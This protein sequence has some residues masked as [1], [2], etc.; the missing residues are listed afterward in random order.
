MGAVRGGGVAADTGGICS[1]SCQLWILCNGEDVREAVL[2][3]LDDSNHRS[4]HFRNGVTL[5]IPPVRLHAGLIHRHKLAR[6]NIDAQE[7]EPA[8][9]E[10]RRERSESVHDGEGQ[11]GLEGQTSEHI[12]HPSSGG[13]GGGR[14]L[15]A[16]EVLAEGG[17]NNGKQDVR[18][19]GVDEGARSGR[20]EVVPVQKA[21]GG[22]ER[23]GNDANL[24]EKEERRPWQIELERLLQP[25]E[26]SRQTGRRL[27][28]GLSRC[29]IHAKETAQKFLI[30]AQSMSKQLLASLR[31]S[32]STAPNSLELTLRTALKASMK[33][34]TPFRTT[35]I[36][37]ILADLQ[38][39]THLVGAAPAESKTL[40]RA[41]AARLDA[42]AI[43][44]SASPPR[45]D[46]AAGNEQE[47]EI[48]REFAVPEPAGMPVE[49][50][51][52]IV[53]ATL[54]EM[55]LSEPGKQMGAI[56]K[57][58]L[59][60]VGDQADGKTISEAVRRAGKA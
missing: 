18:I 30:L 53:Q 51:D 2:K 38:T 21:R 48:L 43:F 29:E 32:Y 11:T 9:P 57:A 55:G 58:V 14:G 8:S 20:A 15:A 7:F 36:K 1:T 28:D 60:K 16:G 59:L 35:V 44:R 52:A 42:S 56:M 4:V 12:E 50:L 46:L 39:A 10:M 26:T 6:S 13:G 27:D 5:L 22:G 3:D 34:R 17:R 37:S 19:G 54:K 47:V 31:R 41:I 49:E 40:A 23:G 24:L 25:R 45:E 33:A